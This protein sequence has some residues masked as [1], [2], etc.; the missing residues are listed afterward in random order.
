[1]TGRE[2]EAANMR[3]SITEATA[4]RREALAKAGT[5][6]DDEYIAARCEVQRAR[7]V[8]QRAKRRWERQYWNSIIQEATEASERNDAGRLHNLLKKL[9]QRDTISARPSEVFSPKEHFQKVSEARFEHPEEIKDLIDNIDSGP[10]TA[11]DRKANAILRKDLTK[12]EI[13][14]AI[15]EMRGGAP[16][17]DGVRISLLRAAHPR[18]IEEAD[19]TEDS[20]R[21]VRPPLYVSTFTTLP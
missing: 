12:T 11:E 10:M 4:K 21:V 18:V 7:A 17:E 9:G 13:L 20:E 1:M 8:Y 5:T 15:S 14:K 16:G 6:E 19:Q 3:Q 2:D